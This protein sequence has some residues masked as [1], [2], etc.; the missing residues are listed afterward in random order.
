MPVLFDMIQQFFPNL[1][2]LLVFTTKM[3]VF[4]GLY[5]F[6]AIF[7]RDFLRHVGLTIEFVDNT[8]SCMDMI[9]SM[10]PLR[11]FER[12]HDIFLFFDA[13]LVTESSYALEIKTAE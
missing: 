3:Q 8:M 2:G 7:G 10:H 12:L 6:D 5:T 11:F 1:I 9:V 4:N 13:S